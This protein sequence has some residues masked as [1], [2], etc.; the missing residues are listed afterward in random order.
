MREQA[1]LNFDG[2]TFDV[3]LDGQRLGTQLADV[4]NVMRGGDWRTLREIISAIGR[5]TETG[6]SARLRDLRKTKFGGWTVESR[7]RTETG[8]WEYRIHKG[9]T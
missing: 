9:E 4:L 5:G 2:N 7:R 8:L 6:I 1:E 3:A